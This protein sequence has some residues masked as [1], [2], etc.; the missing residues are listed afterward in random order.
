MLEKSPKGDLGGF[1]SLIWLS[2]VDEF[3]TRHGL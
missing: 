3:R 1:K 2:R